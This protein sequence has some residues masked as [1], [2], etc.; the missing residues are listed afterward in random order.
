M[1]RPREPLRLPGLRRESTLRWEGQCRDCGAWNTLVETRRAGAPPRAARRRVTDAASGAPGAP[2]P[3][4][5]SHRA[6]VPRLPRRASARWTGCSA[7]VSCRERSCCSAASRASASRRS[8]WRPLPACAPNGSAMAGSRHG[9]VCLR[10]GVGRPAAPAGRAPRPDRRVAG[11]R[12]EVLAETRGRRD[13]G[14]RG[15][16]APA[17]LIVD[18]VQTLTATGLE[19]PAGSV[20]QVRES[21][22]RLRPGR[23]EHGA[24]GLVGHVTKDGSLAGPEDA[25]APGGRGADARGR[26]LRRRCGCCARAK[27]RFGS[28]EEVGV[29]EMTGE[30]LREVPDPARAFLGESARRG[31]GRR[32]RGHAGGQPAAADRGAG[33]G[34][35]R[36]AIGVP[37][38][39]VAGMD[40]NRLAL[41]VAVL[42]RRAG[43][44]LANQDLYASLAG[45]AAVRSRPWTCRSPWRWPP[46]PRPAACAGH[47]CLR[48]GVAARASCGRSG[49]WSD[50]CVR[51]PGS[52]SPG[53]RARHGAATRPARRRPCGPPSVRIIAA[54]SLRDA[55]LG[56]MGRVRY[57]RGRVSGR[58][59][60][61]VASSHA[62]ASC[63]CSGGGL[64]VILAIA[65]TGSRCTGAAL[66]PLHRRAP[67][68]CS[69]GWRLVRRW[70]T[71][72]C[73]TSRSSPPS[74]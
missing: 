10:R 38:R 62:C 50:G 42:G 40:A 33:A 28:T 7:A 11:E 39:T 20:G 65:L 52:G 4:A 72:S 51:R 58:R 49:A 54:E 24:R 68:C 12:I 37:R 36:P 69:P 48:R 26:S 9:A 21:A 18:S 46:V 71:R 19:G 27:N 47:R 61:L 17:L 16:R 73:R 2:R 3:S 66:R 29:L 64:G 31:A 13:P 55:L 70:A 23:T 32:R 67:S 30:G 6:A 63:D 22:A 41:L 25:G 5:R 15:E 14:R 1:A 56:R 60:V 43:M 35:A 59:L 34:G 44:N 53:D 8:C 74:A 57:L 45:G